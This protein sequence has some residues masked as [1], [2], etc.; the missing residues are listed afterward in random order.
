MRLTSGNLASRLFCNRAF[1]EIKKLGDGL[2]GSTSLSK[3]I[4]TGRIVAI[5][6]IFTV[7]NPKME[8]LFM[9]E[10]AIIANA[11]HPNIL[12]FLG[13]I[14]SSH[15]GKIPPSIVS[16]YMPKGSLDKV[17][18]QISQNYSNIVKNA[19]EENFLSYNSI[20]DIWP[21]EYYYIK[22][23]MKIAVGIVEAMIYL[24][25]VKHIVH[26]NL[27]PA[28]ILIDD[29]Y[30]AY[31]SDFG[32]SEFFNKKSTSIQF[33][34]TPLYLSPEIIRKEEV[35][36]K[37]D[38]YAFS[39]ILYQIVTGIRPFEGEN[40][41]SK[42][43]ARVSEGERPTIPKDIP[44]EMAK[45]IKDCWNDN[46]DLRPTFSEILER[47]KTMNFDSFPLDKDDS[48][49]SNAVN[50]FISEYSE[51]VKESA[52]DFKYEEEKTCSSVFQKI[53]SCKQLF[54]AIWFLIRIMQCY[55]LTFSNDVDSVMSDAGPVFSWF[56]RFYDKL[57]NAIFGVRK[58]TNLQML[59]ISS[60]PLTLTL[61]FTSFCNRR[62]PYGSQNGI[63]TVLLSL[64]LVPLA[65]LIGILCYSN[66]R[67]QKWWCYVVLSIHLLIVITYYVLSRVLKKR[68]N[69]DYERNLIFLLF[70]F[71]FPTSFYLDLD[72]YACDDFRVDYF[73]EN[74]V[75]TIF[76]TLF[77][78]LLIIYMTNNIAFGVI[79]AIICLILYIIY[80]IYRKVSHFGVD[81]KS[82]D[83]SFGPTVRKL[84]LIFQTVFY[85]P[86]SEFIFRCI[87]ENLRSKSYQ[88]TVEPGFKNIEV[89]I[90]I[91][92]LIFTILITILF[93]VYF[94][95]RAISFRNI[96]NPYCFR[97]IMNNCSTFLGFNCSDLKAQY[98]WFE[99]IDSIARFLFA[100][101]TVYDLNWVALAMNLLEG[102]FVIAARPYLCPSDNILGASEMIVLAIA[103]GFSAVELSGS[104]F[105]HWYAF[106]I[107][108]LAI[109]PLIASL[110]VF[111]IFELHKE[112]KF[113][114]QD[115]ERLIKSQENDRNRKN[116][117]NSIRYNNYANFNA[118][119]SF[120]NDSDEL[121]GFNIEDFDYPRNRKDQFGLDYRS[122][123]RLISLVE[124]DPKFQRFFSLVF[125][126]NHMILGLPIVFSFL[127]WNNMKKIFN[128]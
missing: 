84:Y 10:F 86:A 4:N 105:K 50:E 62:K 127:F 73:V 26:R 45:L 67:F 124:D 65:F 94:S 20:K 6:H 118:S 40:D 117:S 116:Y 39:I 33:G 51:N 91:Y 29:E 90:V 74:T 22:T 101:F 57:F 88:K 55:G 100:G 27:K 60:C 2:V 66:F 69:T 110:T 21:D 58:F 93:L 63:F 125:Q 53:F 8:E 115:I 47:L 37:S 43:L 56:N 9:N 79:V 7:K 113:I 106:L 83:K 82:I 107:I 64:L 78:T 96:L 77:T 111:F 41:V 122:G 17:F 89:P 38:V 24:H 44:I 1:E 12:P 120:W 18:K 81:Q 54:Q 102:L 92:S 14:T 112:E 70:M 104:T 108:A 59:I 80:C 16:V 11:R 36:L 72:K 31:V 5:K 123:T 85:I 119:G 46:K 103:N 34:G 23:R 71:G 48:K 76:S 25:D 13:F 68:R 30:N 126:K 15:H 75:I 128:L 49:S 42:L 97:F 99:P 28:N 109:V 121:N 87:R 114:N 98:L 95:Y 35:D 32:L 52:K 3:E 61:Y 19:A